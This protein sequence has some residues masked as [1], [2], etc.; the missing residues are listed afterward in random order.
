M[1]R[2]STIPGPHGNGGVLMRLRSLAFLLVCGSTIIGTSCV[3]DRPPRVELSPATFVPAKL[4]LVLWVDGLDIQVFNSLRQAGRLPNITKYLIDRGV[5]VASAVGSLPTITYANNVSFATGLFPGHHGVVGNKWFDRYALVFQDYSFIKSY[6]Q[7]DEDFTA[8]TIYEALADEYTASILTPVRRGATR[9][10]DNWATAG[11]AWF[12]GYQ[13]TVNHLT[14]VRFELIARLADRTGR[15]PRFVLAYFVTPDTVGHAC[16]P[17]SQQYT[18]MVLDIDR[19]VG[20]ICRSL[21]KA[22]LL[23]RTYV[24][25][26]CD[27]GF[28]ETPEHAEIAEYF[29][30]NLKIPTISRMYGRGVS[31]EKRLAHFARARAVVVTGGNRRCS[32]HL[33]PGEHWWQRPTEKDIDAFL[34]RFGAYPGRP[35]GTL[36]GRRAS[37]PQLLAALPATD[38]VMVRRDNHSV[39]VQNEDGVG[40]IDRVVRSGR[41]LYRYRVVSGT[42]PL[43]YASNPEAAALMDG[44]HHDA[45]TWLRASRDTDRPDVA[46]Q[47]IELNDSARNGDITLFAADGW[48]FSRGD[49]GGHGGLLRHEIVVPWV[50]AGPDLPAGARIKCART[51]DLMP[52]MLHLIGRG[53]AVPDGLDGRSLAERLRQAGRDRQ[54]RQDRGGERRTPRRR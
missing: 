24:T 48:D 14:T 21:E 23:E 30:R 51:V 22:G 45:E 38:L 47:L 34:D 27:H 52:T 1:S 20:H 17:A 25:L 18:D 11:V 32:I 53:D 42:D 7:V 4:G 37:L 31:F 6:Q 50:W 28:V 26:I 2:E 15:W 44:E 3:P 5:T 46:V 8:Q 9:N 36:D 43:G 13:A 54:E 35:R 49:R 12:F 33:R 40:V 16:G 19:Q 29:Q 39:R 41:K 10:I